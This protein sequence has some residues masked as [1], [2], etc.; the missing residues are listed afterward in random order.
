MQSQPDR[1]Q[2]PTSPEDLVQPA[3]PIGQTQLDDQPP[4]FCV[5]GNTLSISKSLMESLDLFESCNENLFTQNTLS[6][7]HIETPSI[8]YGAAESQALASGPFDLFADIIPDEE[9]P[10]APTLGPT[11]PTT[12]DEKPADDDATPASSEPFPSTQFGQHT[13]S[14][15]NTPAL[16]TDDSLRPIESTQAPTG[17]ESARPKRTRKSRF[18]IENQEN[19]VFSDYGD[20]NRPT[21]K[22][23]RRVQS[24][25]TK[26]QSS[27]SAGSEEPQAAAAAKVLKRKGSA[28]LGDITNTKAPRLLNENVDSRPK[29]VEE[30]EVCRRE[31]V[32]ELAA[33][34]SSPQPLTSPILHLKVWNQKF[35]RQ[36]GEGSTAQ[37]E[38]EEAWTAAE[39]LVELATPVKSP[40]P[41]PRKPG[42]TAIVYA[43]S[44]AELRAH[45]VTLEMVC[46]DDFGSPLSVQQPVLPSFTTFSQS[47]NYQ[48]WTPTLG[49]LNPSGLPCS[50]I[51]SSPSSY[52][53]L[54]IC[55][56]N[57]HQH[58]ISTQERDED[59]LGLNIVREAPKVQTPPR[60]PSQPTQDTSTNSAEESEGSLEEASIHVSDWEQEP[61]E[62]S[63]TP[64]EIQKDLN[65]TAD[66]LAKKQLEMS[67][68]DESN[69]MKYALIK[70]HELFT[71]EE[72][73]NGILPFGKGKCRSKTRTPLDPA[74]VEQVKEALA[75][76]FKL[77]E[78]Y[79]DILWNNMR[80]D[81]NRKLGKP[82]A[83]PPRGKA[84]GL[85]VKLFNKP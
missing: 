21:N 66:L 27:S 15:A 29:L 64:A 70:L 44:D 6:T 52:L 23:K 41:S 34:V 59:D 76:K 69:K 46:Y 48:S 50:P 57:A 32:D 14:I 65:K 47:F 16:Q 61:E 26:R 74:R 22:L 10:K 62:A 24:M 77:D 56:F 35:S 45:G 2:T 31:P 38:S 7:A 84:A 4:Y 72:L 12:Q 33:L 79:T 55:K 18:V 36:L 42:H 28:P 82:L 25:G 39:T 73:Q 11:D 60:R 75:D 78:F 13:P 81:L 49:G 63:I 8:S 83:K 51:A 9:E 85:K 58:P 20:E 37:A 19:E 54:G 80:A 5:D 53:N 30:V 71:P 17:S 68:V 43:N 40:L 3:Q 1:C 67:A